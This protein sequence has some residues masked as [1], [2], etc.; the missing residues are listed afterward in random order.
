MEKRSVKRT[1]LFA[2][3]VT[4]ALLVGGC[5]FLAPKGPELQNWEPAISPDGSAVAFESPAAKG[6]ELYTLTLATGEKRRLTENEVDD[7]SP[8]FSPQGDRIVFVSNRE[9]NVDLYVIT[10]DTLA[11]TRLTSDAGDDLNPSWAASGKILFNSNR[12]GAWEIYMIDP[13]G[14]NL[15]KATGA[16]D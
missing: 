6:F 4:F 9:K 16:A 8:S 1:A 12:S 3:T 13:D 2:V 15:T 11:V 10:L 14:A 7:W 5:S